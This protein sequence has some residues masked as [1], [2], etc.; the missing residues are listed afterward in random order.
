MAEK[1]EVI[2]GFKFK[3]NHGKQRVRVGRVWKDSNGVHHFVEWNVGVNLFSDCIRSYTHD[4]NSD[5][6]ATDTMKN[7]VTF[8]IP[9]S[10]FYLFLYCLHH[11]CCMSCLTL[12]SWLGRFVVKSVIC[13]VLYYLSLLLLI[14]F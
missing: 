3:Q 14:L 12:F 8:L 11:C 6:V 2:N 9:I 5:I 13:L 7:T 1:E 10:F 4:D